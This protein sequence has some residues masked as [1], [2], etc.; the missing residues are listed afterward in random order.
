MEVAFEADTKKG[1]ELESLG[2]DRARWNIK[3][4]SVLMHKLAELHNEKQHTER[5][6]SLD[7]GALV[8]VEITVLQECGRL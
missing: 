6:N 8:T 2:K 4:I 1:L 7:S 3:S 5:P